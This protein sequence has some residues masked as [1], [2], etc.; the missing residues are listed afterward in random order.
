MKSS[1]PDDWQLEYSEIEEFRNKISKTLKTTNGDTGQVVIT[2]RQLIL[3]L[4]GM[5]YMRECI[6]Q[7]Q[8]SD[9]VAPKGF[10]RTKGDDNYWLDAARDFWAETE[11]RTDLVDLEII[12][13]W[14]DQRRSK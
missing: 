8:S 5:E 6:Q 11:L 10:S 1:Y 7:Y 14:F 13:N 12:L 9:Y 4:E 2:A 3:L